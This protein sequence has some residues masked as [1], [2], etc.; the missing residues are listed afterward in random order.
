MCSTQKTIDNV[1][2][3]V[4]GHPLPTKVKMDSEGKL[5]IKGY[6]VKV[7]SKRTYI[8]SWCGRQ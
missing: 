7:K 6:E 1:A 4:L 8:E 5:N 3:M 2:V